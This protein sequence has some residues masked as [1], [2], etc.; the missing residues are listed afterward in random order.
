MNSKV[1]VSFALYI[2]VAAVLPNLGMAQDTTASG[3]NSSLTDMERYQLQLEELASEFGPMDNSL[4]EPL[5]VM[6][7]ILLEEGEFEQVAEIQN[8]QMSIMR[9]NLGFE[10][11]DLIPL[12]RGMIQVQQVLGNWESINNHLEH[13]QF[14]LSS[15]YG[16]QSEELLLAVENQAQWL[17]A[18]FYLDEERKQ[19]DNFLDTRDLYR[20]MQQ[21]AEDVYG[22]DSPELYPW[23]YKRAYNLALMV[24]LL[25]TKD[26]FALEFLNDVIRSDGTIRLQ[27]G[28]GITNTSLNPIG[29]WNIRNRNFVLGEGY[30][31]QARG[32]INDIREIAENEGDKEVQ[33][34]AQIYR[35]DYNVLMGRGSGRQQ[36]NEAKEKLVAAGVPLADIEEFFRTP[37]PLPVP[38]F[39]ARFDELLMYQRSIIS[40]VDVVP[41]EI[42]HL[43]IFSAWHENASAVL[44]PVS[45]D[46]LLQI[47]MPQY[48]VDLSFNISSR[49]NV[50]SVE[51]INSVPDN[52]RVA[53]EGLRAV[54]E[55]KFRPR[56]EGK[57][58]ERTK[59]VQMRYLFA[60]EL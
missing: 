55:I 2:V 26:G 10:N 28:G 17:L 41:E 52:R 16:N 32:F 50:S 22:E 27:T 54:R 40:A 49:G 37:M 44:K 60:Q 31:R 43:G 3:F 9:T 14:L 39:Y 34:I 18:R 30:L 58:V 13:I 33:A 8:R 45:S 25:N 12:L 42:L 21:L 48:L 46:P 23:Y 53:R 35:G 20:N 5:T 59:D 29:V 1:S 56:M 47:G 11:P 38:Q 7:T 4:L 24:Q 6:L 57:R 36:Y 15:T 19:S 51:V